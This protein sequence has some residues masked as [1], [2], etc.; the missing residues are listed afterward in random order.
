MLCLFDNVYDLN[1]YGCPKI[2]SY[3]H[4]MGVWTY[5]DSIDLYGIDWSTCENLLC[6][7][8]LS[9]ILT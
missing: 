3:Y 2:S 8:F 6:S 5:L 9:H 7:P 4:L 1:G